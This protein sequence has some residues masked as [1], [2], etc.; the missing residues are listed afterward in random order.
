M[1]RTSALTHDW[2]RHILDAANRDHSAL[3]DQSVLN[4]ATFTAPASSTINGTQGT[5][6][7]TE[8]GTRTFA[9]NGT[10]HGHDLEPEGKP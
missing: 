9:F 10:W 5:R 4:G 3:T 7:T 2:T 8:L 1:N 6:R